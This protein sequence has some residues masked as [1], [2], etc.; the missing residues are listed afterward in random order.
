MTLLDKIEKLNLLPKMERF[1]GQ[2]GA[3]GGYK[4]NDKYINNVYIF[5]DKIIVFEKTK[6][7][8]IPVAI[9]TVLLDVFKDQFINVNDLNEIIENLTESIAELNAKLLI[10]EQVDVIGINRKMDFLEGYFKESL[11]ENQNIVMSELSS[12][13]EK[14]ANLEITNINVEKLN[15]DFNQTVSNMVDTKLTD[16]Y[17][18]FNHVVNDLVSTEVNKIK[19]SI[20]ENSNKLKPGIIMIYKEMGLTIEQI[21]E[22]KKNDMI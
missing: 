11:E 1:E 19:G 7:T 18:N 8:E 12:F 22:L 13:R 5:N 2:D 6:Y 9:V 17:K 4:Y 14:L 16:V 3:E 20:I 21:I 15:N 10:Q